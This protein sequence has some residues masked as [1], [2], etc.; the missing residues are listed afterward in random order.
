[1][2]TTVSGTQGV[3]KVAPNSVDQEDLKWVPP[4][5]KEF[6]SAEQQLSLGALITVAHGLGAAPKL[7]DM[8]LVCVNTEQ[9]WVAGDVIRFGVSFFSQSFPNGDGMIAYADATNIYVRT[10]NIGIPV[11]NKT[12]GAVA[13]IS[14]T[15][16]NLVVRAWA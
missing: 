8:N 2:T 11:M 14:G 15:N 16:F 9:G 12:I 4:F 3:D 7:I 5:T 6:A 13:R 10:G 1:M